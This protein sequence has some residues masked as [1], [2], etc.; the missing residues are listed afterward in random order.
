MNCPV[1]PVSRAG[2]TCAFISTRCQLSRIPVIILALC[3]ASQPPPLLCVPSS[4][5]TTW[6][7][8]LT[9][10]S[11]RALYAPAKHL[12]PSAPNQQPLSTI[13]MAASKGRK[14]G[15]MSRVIRV[16]KVLVLGTVWMMNEIGSLAAKICPNAACY[17]V[18]LA[19]VGGRGGG[20]PS[21]RSLTCSCSSLPP[22]H[23]QPVP[24]LTVFNKCEFKEE[25]RLNANADDRGRTTVKSPEAQ[26][27]EVGDWWLHKARRTPT[28]KQ[29]QKITRY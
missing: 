14:T 26:A 4:P 1:I 7:L 27:S 22:T 6:S 12:W 9:S 3:S 19:V 13:R 29:N 28:R 18:S 2:Q 5:L 10:I 25:L 17:R 20:E 24:T 11:L 15:S 16:W 23:H 8:N 21:R